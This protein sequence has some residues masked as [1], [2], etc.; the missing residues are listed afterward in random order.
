MAKFSL[1]KGRELSRA[2]FN[3]LELLVVM[4]LIAVLASLSVPAIASLSRGGNVSRATSAAATSLELAR[5]HAVAH[6]TYTWVIFGTNSEASKQA[7]HIVILGSKDGTRTSDG[8]TPV[9]LE[10][11]ALYDLNN[12]A[13]NLYQLGKAESCAGARL[14]DSTS[15]V[16]PTSA[17][18]FLFPGSVESIAFLNQHPELQRVVQF[19]PN[20]QARVS[21]SPSQIIGMAVASS[22]SPEGD[23]VNVAKIQIDGFTGLTRVIRQ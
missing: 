8:V 1:C 20:G 12:G 10:G 15:A 19:G 4:A 21:G 5:Q 6:N 13:K 2:G 16:S 7:V 18:R 9:E 3:L 11:S 14:E 17:A 23:P 22:N